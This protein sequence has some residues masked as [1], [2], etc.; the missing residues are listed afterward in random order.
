MIALAPFISG[1]REESRQ[2]ED[3]EEWDEEEEEKDQGE[4]KNKEASPAGRPWY[5]LSQKRVFKYTPRK[6]V[7][8]FLSKYFY[9][10]RYET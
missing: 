3:R 10:I 9:F 6:K 7:S 5:S 2:K 4:K 1:E 8:I